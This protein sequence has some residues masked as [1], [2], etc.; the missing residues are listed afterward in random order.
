MHRRSLSRTPGLSQSSRR[1]F[2]AFRLFL[3][4]LV[5]APLASAGNLIFVDQA[6]ST[7]F[8]NIQ[9]AV[10]SAQPG[11]LIYIMAGE[12]EGFT[13][14][15]RS[16]HLAAVDGAEVTV[17]GTMTVRNIALGSLVTLRGI[18]STGT[19][20]PDPA[21][22]EGLVV[23]NCQ[24]SI[25]VSDCTLEGFAGNY[26]QTPAL[27][28]DRCD[29]V[30]LSSCRL[31]QDYSAFGSEGLLA[32]DSNLSLFQ[33]TVEGG[34]SEFLGGDGVH[35][36]GSSGQ[37]FA[38]DCRFSGGD[39]LDAYCSGIGSGIDAG[40]GGVGFYNEGWSV[41]LQDT[42]LVGGS[43]GYGD[44][45]EWGQPCGSGG[46]NGLDSVGPFSVL[47]GT[48]PQLQMAGVVHEALGTLDVL[49]SGVPGE[50]VFLLTSLAGQ[51][52][53]SPRFDGPRLL[54]DPLLGM[55]HSTATGAGQLGGGIP[56]GLQRS[57][58]GT[59][60]A[61]GV[62]N[63]Q[64]PI[65]P[66]SSSGLLASVQFQALFVEPGGGS[67][68]TN[69]NTLAILPCSTGLDCNGNGA[70]D[71]CDIVSG[72]SL[73]CNG[74]GVPDECEW[75][76]NQNG[77][78]DDCDILSGSSL[79]LNGNGTP[80]EC[81]GLVRLHVD[82][83]AA[84]GGDGLSW[85]TAFNDLPTA[86]DFHAAH[87]FEM[88]ELWV[89]EGVYLPTNGPQ[90]KRS[91][92]PGDEVRMRGGFAGTETVLSQR[93]LTAHETVLSGD[94]AGDDLFPAGMDEN[95]HTVL[96][97]DRADNV[98]VDG[99]T[100]RGGN[101]NVG[102]FRHGAGLKI[103][104]SRNFVISR[105]TIEQN[106]AS[107]GGGGVEITG[108]QSEVDGGDFI[109]CVI[110]NNQAIRSSPTFGGLAGGILC[111]QWLDN[112]RLIGCEITGNHADRKA[113][114]A[115]SVDSPVQFLECTIADNTCDDEGG[116][117]QVIDQHVVI[118]GCVLWGNTSASGLPQY[119]G[120]LTGGDW[121][122]D[123]RL[124]CIEGANVFPGPGNINLDPVF[125][126]SYRYRK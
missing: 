28:V 90:R 59:I 81:E 73:D 89:A 25:R 61:L 7:G 4:L 84:P 12:Y 37:L 16:V 19:Y 118:Q 109:N 69:A 3:G 5:S 103:N 10:T 8:D 104:R 78:P 112:L 27:T 1:P 111:G 94:L 93:I 50:R 83:N 122:F 97:L 33:T 63:V 120:Q 126:C 117:I 36:V 35:L 121:Y 77:L 48:G 58:V 31:T 24:G 114:A 45:D 88:E 125:V 91:F 102:G 71:A 57:Y 14:A 30:A 87:P 68:W 74:N 67:Q 39:G 15:N 106:S 42:A 32:M 49:F 51:F 101:A 40:D 66:G 44:S 99:F 92:R 54:A 64:V 75:D 21:A 6:G 17:N 96:F 52:E 86:F 56:L 20:S 38:T 72:T 22:R 23:R 123:T 46:S 2:R 82:V 79:D 85:A 119:T 115:F 34:V 98:L 70:A 107:V 105:C 108:I 62:L 80:D 124:S 13:I 100:V 60:D 76:C 43:G 26:A 29:D 113:G 9:D 116:G 11:D 95:S 53:F 41:L 65:L 110:R 47:P 18:D 55:I